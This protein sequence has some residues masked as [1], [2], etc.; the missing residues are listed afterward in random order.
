M[1]SGAAEH[2]YAARHNLTLEAPKDIDPDMLA[3]LEGMN[4][5][6]LKIC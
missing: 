5:T 3:E 4:L 2:L 6:A 1:H